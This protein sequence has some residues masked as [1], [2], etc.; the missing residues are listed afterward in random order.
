MIN[1]KAG[2]VWCFDHV[3]VD[4]GVGA[5]VDVMHDITLVPP[6]F[7]VPRLFG[8]GLTHHARMSPLRIGSIST[9][10]GIVY[11]VRIFH[12][13]DSFGSYFVSSKKIELSVPR[14]VLSPLSPSRKTYSCRLST[15]LKI[16][17]AGT[18]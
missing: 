3:D 2:L 15:Y 7:R 13:Y 18:L 6:A 5:D 11:M 1:K 16:S 9:P 4:V 14:L 10:H 17:I 12:H 8:A